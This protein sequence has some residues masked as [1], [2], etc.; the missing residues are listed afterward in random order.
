MVL[1]I[2]H[3]M[4]DFALLLVLQLFDP[5]TARM[6]DILEKTLRVESFLSITMGQMLL[7]V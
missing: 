6:E 1:S 3:I 4:F 2:G 5:N 7:L